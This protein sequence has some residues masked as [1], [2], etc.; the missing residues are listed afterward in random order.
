MKRFITLSLTFI[1]CLAVMSGCSEDPKKKLLTLFD[2]GSEESSV[3]P[4]TNAYYGPASVTATDGQY[5]DKVGINWATVS[6]AV[7]YNIYRSDNVAG[8]FTAKIATVDAEDLEN[9]DTSVVTT[10]AGTT[11]DTVTTTASS[12]TCVP[13]YQASYQSVRDIGSGIHISYTSSIWLIGVGW[14]YTSEHYSIRLRLGNVVDTVIEFIGKS[15]PFGTTW[16][17]DMIVAEFNNAMGSYGTCYAVTLNGKKYIKIVS[18]YPITLSSDYDLPGN[19][20][21]VGMHFLDKNVESSTVITASPEIIACNDITRPTV[22]DVSP[23]NGKTDI[24]LNAKVSVAFSEPVDPSTLT[25][26][27]FTLSAGGTPVSG[28]VSNT[29][30][31]TPASELSAGTTYTATI[32]T[33]VKDLAGNSLASNYVWTF[34]TSASSTMSYYYV[35]TDVEQGSHYYYAVTAVDSVGRE[36]EPSPVEE[37]FV[38]A[39]DNVPSKVTNCSASDGFPGGITVSWTAATGATS[40]TVYRIDSSGQ[41][42]VGSSINGTSY[43][44]TTAGPGIFS[45][46]VAPFNA[47][48]EGGSSDPDAGFRTVSNQ[49]FFDQVYAEEESGLSRI[50]KLQQ[51][52]LNMVGTETVYDLNGSGNCYYDAGYDLWTD[53]ATVLITFTNFCDIYLTLNGTQTTLANSSANGTITGQLNVTGIYPGYVKFNLAIT[54]GTASGGTYT[55]SQDGGVT[56]TTI[57][58]SYVPA[59]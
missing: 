12:G 23:D 38:K 13:V 31:F 14:T 18:S 33:A 10:D 34:T 15:W 36:S 21:W 2:A 55:V 56:E 46:K 39:N 16:T 8:P 35:D 30:V 3:D 25:Q 28:T 58:Y 11:P 43:T 7:S 22:T 29:G 50:N 24:A 4:E 57:P 51:S 52:G 27:S 20:L 17:Q 32:T 41:T 47:S 42:Q 53:K 40:Y 37:G 5:K 19:I 59:D 54:G 45:Y 26:S 44:D 6:N 9:D 49:E 1:S 48:G